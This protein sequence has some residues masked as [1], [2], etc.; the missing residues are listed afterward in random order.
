MLQVLHD[1]FI[2]STIIGRF[3]AWVLSVSYSRQGAWLRVLSQKV[4]KVMLIE[5]GDPGEGVSLSV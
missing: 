3:V 2:K 1:V 4:E 5:A